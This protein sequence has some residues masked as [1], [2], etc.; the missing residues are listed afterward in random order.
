MQSE[1][2]IEAK[3][4]AVA[5][6]ERRF[7]HNEKVRRRAARKRVLTNLG[8]IVIGLAVLAGVAYFFLRRDAGWRAVN[9]DVEQVTKIINEHIPIAV[10]P[11]AATPSADAPDVTSVPIV[12]EAPVVTTKKTDVT[13][14]F[15][16]RYASVAAQFLKG[17][18]TPWKDAPKELRPKTAPAGT[19]FHALVA[20][21]G[22]FALYE[23]KAGGKIAELSPFGPPLPLA[24]GDFKKACGNRPY[25]IA[26]AGRVFV[27]GNADL[28]TMDE[29][30]KALLAH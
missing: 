14:E 21:G 16:E 6:V 5:L 27:C 1:H 29:L 2:E 23:L 4:E 25:F 3:R 9:A 24:S 15:R 18:L 22:K 11:S 8:S 17:E 28:K 26:C 13:A 7:E 19:I 10:T 12:S 20:N 30:R